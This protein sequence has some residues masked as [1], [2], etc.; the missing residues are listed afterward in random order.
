[1]FPCPAPPVLALLLT[2]PC[3]NRPE[4]KNGHSEPCRAP[5]WHLQHGATLSS[6]PLGH[7]QEE[8]RAPVP[9]ASLNAAG[10]LSPACGRHQVQHV[11]CGADIQTPLLLLLCK[12][13]A[14][15]VTLFYNLHGA[16]CK[17]IDLL[18]MPQA[19]V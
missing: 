5:R 18:L 6:W 12:Q 15:R 10:L 3:P 14:A 17:G 4:G 1:M 11:S 16:W 8:P 7:G 2:Y 13:F 9:T 19:F